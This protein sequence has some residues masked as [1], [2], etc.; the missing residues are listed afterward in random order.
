VDSKGRAELE[1]KI[2]EMARF[3]SDR[4]RM[5]H[6]LQLDFRDGKIINAELTEIYNSLSELIEE[7][8]KKT[9]FREE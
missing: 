3:F 7:I 9:P 8:K 6:D 5:R 4:S 2:S 1:Q